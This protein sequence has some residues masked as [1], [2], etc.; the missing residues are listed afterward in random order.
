MILNYKKSENIFI[1]KC[2][3]SEKNQPKDTGFIWNPTKKWWWT[4]DAET[5]SIFSG[6]ANDMTLEYLVV[7]LKKIEEYR[8]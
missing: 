3:F 2:S 4:K 7:E 8:K 1:L 6:Y 5:A